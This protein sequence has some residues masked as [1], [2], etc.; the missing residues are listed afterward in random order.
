M[1]KTQRGAAPQRSAWQAWARLSEAC[2]GGARADSSTEGPRAFPAE[3]YELRHG[4]AQW[5]WIE[6]W[7]G[8]FRWGGVCNGKPRHQLRQQHWGLRLPLLLSFGSRCGVDRPGGTRQGMAG[9]GTIWQ[10]LI[11]ALSPTGLSAGFYGIQIGRG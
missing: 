3:F 4:V 11:S 6:M 5:G 1:R 7:C 8:M 9:R 2:Q 10:G